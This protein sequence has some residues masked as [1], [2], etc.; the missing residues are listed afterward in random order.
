MVSCAGELFRRDARVE[1][2]GLEMRAISM[3]A[4]W[5]EWYRGGP[6]KTVVVPAKR[7]ASRDP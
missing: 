5:K 4:K 1:T 6:Q 3:M 2:I 7:I